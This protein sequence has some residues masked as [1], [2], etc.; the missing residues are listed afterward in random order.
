MAASYCCATARINSRQKLGLVDPNLVLQQSCFF[1][2]HIGE[3]I[4]HGS[5]GDRLASSDSEFEM[6]QG[7]NMSL[8]CRRSVVGATCTLVPITFRHKLGLVGLTARKAGVFLSAHI[9]D[10]VQPGSGGG[11]RHRLARSYFWRQGGSWRECGVFLCE[12]HRFLGALRCCCCCC[13]S[14]TKLSTLSS[15]RSIRTASNACAHLGCPR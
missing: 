9:G 11:R 4:R 3:G 13:C 1:S 2:A 5:D 6:D 8:S 14:H 12:G 7:Q 10:G 15:P